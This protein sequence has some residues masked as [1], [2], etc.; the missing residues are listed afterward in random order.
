MAVALCT[1]VCQDA[2]QDFASSVSKIVELMHIPMFARA[3]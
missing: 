2:K 3:H 1:V